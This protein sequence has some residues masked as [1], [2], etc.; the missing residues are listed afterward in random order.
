VNWLEVVPPPSAPAA[1]KGKAEEE[2]W[3]MADWAQ[4]V[5]SE[6]DDGESMSGD[7]RKRTKTVLIFENGRWQTIPRYGRTRFRGHW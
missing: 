1:G 3:A 7:P 5:R 6:L 2:D 4:K